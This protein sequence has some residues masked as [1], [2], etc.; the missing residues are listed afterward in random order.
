MQLSKSYVNSKLWMTTIDM[1]KAEGFDT[2]ET[3]LQRYTSPWGQPINIVQFLNIIVWWF[4]L[5]LKIQ[6]WNIDLL[7][8]FWGVLND[9]TLTSHIIF[10]ESSSWGPKL[11]FYKKLN[12]MV[13]EAIIRNWISTVKSST[14]NKWTYQITTRMPDYVLRMRPWARSKMHALIY[15]PMSLHAKQ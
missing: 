2:N 14:Q 1:Y 6:G 15:N 3:S 7:R 5:Q 11:K 8:H 13:F 4:S 10:G 9:E 12:V